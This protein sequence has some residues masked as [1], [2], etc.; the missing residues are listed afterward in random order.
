MGP[1]GVMEGLQMGIVTHRVVYLRKK[2][3]QAASETFVNI[4]E[5][6]RSSKGL[7]ELFSYS[8]HDV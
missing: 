2:E 1:S 8:A 5:Q 6:M 7:F 4:I 3:V